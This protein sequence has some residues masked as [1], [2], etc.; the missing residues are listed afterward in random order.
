MAKGWF[1]LEAA[2]G[3]VP[4][5]TLWEGDSA[6]SFLGLTRQQRI[7]GFVG[8]YVCVLRRTIYYS[9]VVLKPA[10]WALDSFSASWAQYVCSSTC[11]ADSLVGAP[12]APRFSDLTLIF[13][14]I[15]MYVCGT[16]VSLVGT[17]FVL[18]VRT[19]VLPP[20]LR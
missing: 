15:A 7:Y 1:N 13:H 4:D 19:F 10:A 17:G 6:F 16:I 12:F 9:C 18:G 20:M 11:L 14:V 8:W 3:V 5:S 2:S